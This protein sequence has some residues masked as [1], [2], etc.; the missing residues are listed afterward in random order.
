MKIMKDNL[1]KIVI[2]AMVIAAIV[3]YFIFFKPLLKE[4][5]VKYAKYKSLD[6]TM[7]KARQMASSAQ[8]QGAE[9]SI[10]TKKDISLAIDELTNRGQEL[11]IDFIALT[12]G[13]S[14]KEALYEVFPIDMEI[15]SGYKKLGLFLGA[16]SKLEKSLISVKSFVIVP[17]EGDNG[18]L[19]AKI[20][21][22]MYLLAQDEE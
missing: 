15:K 12:P 10:L 8:A 18:K 11:S 17:E 9:S 13:K 4:L 1:K 6:S 21:L 5:E 20:S 22:K 14:E 7:V 16:L 2:S 19:K 3:V